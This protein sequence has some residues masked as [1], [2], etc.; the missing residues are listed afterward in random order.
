M[1]G[2]LYGASLAATLAT[3]DEIGHRAL[4]ADAVEDALEGSRVAVHDVTLA[5]PDGSRGTGGLE[6]VLHQPGL[7]RPVRANELSDG[8]LRFLLLAAALLSPRPPG[9]LVL[10]EPET[11]LHPRLIDPLARLVVDAYR[12]SQIGLV[13]HSDALA[14]ALTAAGAEH[15]HLEKSG[16]E[17]VVS[18]LG[19][20]ERPAWRWPQR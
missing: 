2:S 16:G 20:L 13:T 7:L 4:L 17:T 12:D 3:I 11:S 9:L 19:W 15:V 5:G 18:D 10:N 8:T 14:A 1:R 6:V